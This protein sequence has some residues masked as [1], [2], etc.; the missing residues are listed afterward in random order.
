VHI[1]VQGFFANWLVQLVGWQHWAGT[2]SSSDV[3]TCESAGAV[4]TSVAA[5]EVVEVTV[6]AGGG[7]AVHP[8]IATAVIKTAKRAMVFLSIHKRIGSLKY[9]HG[10]TRLR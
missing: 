2:Q 4:V 6:V 9:K 7:P 1:T 8:A 3:Q 5:G 10:E